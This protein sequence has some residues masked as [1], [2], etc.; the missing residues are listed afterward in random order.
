MVH[1]KAVDCITGEVLEDLDTVNL[2]GDE[3]RLQRKL[4]G[5]R[6]ISVALTLRPGATHARKEIQSNELS[7]LNS[8]E[9]GVFI[10][11]SSWHPQL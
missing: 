4:P 2:R 8:S 7:N 6:D 5:P 10:I 11:E 1:Y 9:G 3:P